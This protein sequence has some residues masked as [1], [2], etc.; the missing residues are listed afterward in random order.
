MRTVRMRARIRSLTA[1]SLA[2]AACAATLAATPAAAAALP[3]PVTFGTNPAPLSGSASDPCGFT[4][5][6]GYIG[7]DDITFNAVISVPGGGSAA[8]EYLIT[9]GDGSAPL[10]YTTG[11]VSDGLTAGLTLPRTDFTDGTTYAWQVRETDS[12]G[13][14]SPYTQ[15]CHFVADHTPPPQPVVTSSV[16]NSSSTPVAR[17]PGTFTFSVPAGTGTVA[18]DYAVDGQLGAG[19]TFPGNGNSFVRVGASGTKTTPTLIPTQPGPNWITVDSVD[20]A[21]NVSQP[22]TYDFFLRTPPPD[23]RGDLNGDGIPDL[24]AVT[25]AGNLQVYFGQGNGQV[26]PKTVFTNSGTGWKGALIAQNGNFTSGS[27]QDLL[28]MQHGSLVAYANNGLGDFTPNSGRVEER[29]NGGD[30]S[31]VTQLIAPGDITGDGLAD[32]ITQEGDLLLLWAGSF[33]GFA[34]GVVIGTGWAGLSVV[35]AADFND[36]GVT[37]LLARDTT[38]NLW[39]YPGDGLGDGSFGDTSTRVLVGTGF[40]TAKYPLVTS[41]GD[42]NGDGLPDLYATTASGGLVF[43]PGVSGGGFGTPVAVTGTK[44]NWANVTGLA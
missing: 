34:P 20:H 8:A 25:A 5:P 29:P 21:G 4:K 43:I 40:T 10:D 37:D 11:Q 41:I 7:N 35:G 16:F 32:V 13:D 38:G 33:S 42:A 28:A 26:G 14:V 39:L 6:Y 44:T 30:W 23:V 1:A 2:A 22:V 31:D 15:A 27:Y 3:T 19:G 36:D 9:P 18:F 12:S 24:A 17:T